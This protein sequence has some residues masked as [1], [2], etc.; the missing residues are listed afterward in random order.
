MVDA[1]M[2]S[3]ILALMQCFVC[4]GQREKEDD[5]TKTDWSFWMLMVSALLWWIFVVYRVWLLVASF[6]TSRETKHVVEQG[7]QTDLVSLDREIEA[8]TRSESSSASV[9]VS[10]RELNRV[11][12]IYISSAQG[13]CFHVKESCFGIRQARAVQVRRP[14]AICCQAVAK[15]S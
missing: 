8:E 15:I 12:R 11:N 6:S 10:L 14:C 13:E 7:I 4:R 3:A 5:S 9:S 1:K 2:F